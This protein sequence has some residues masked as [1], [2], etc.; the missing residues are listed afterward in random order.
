MSSECDVFL[1]RKARVTLLKM[2]IDGMDVVAMRGAAKLF[3]SGGVGAINLEF[4]PTKHKA[5]SGVSDAI[6]LQELHALGCAP[7]QCLRHRT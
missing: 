3:S 4:S 2:D 1:L 6:Y 7:P 5:A